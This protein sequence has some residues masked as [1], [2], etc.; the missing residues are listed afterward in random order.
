[1]VCQQKQTGKLMIIQLLAGYII[2]KIIT[3]MIRYFIS[4]N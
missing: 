4:L 1:M 2:I 3:I